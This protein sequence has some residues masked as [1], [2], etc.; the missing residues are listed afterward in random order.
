MANTIKSDVFEIMQYEFKPGT[1]EP[2]NFNE[3]NIVAGLNHKTIKEWAYIKH[4]KDTYT[5]KDYDKFV[6]I[7]P[8]ESPRFEVGD[9]KNVHWH[10]VIKCTPRIDVETVARWFGVPEWQVDVPKGRGKWLDKIEYLTHE[11]PR[12]QEQGKHRYDDSEVQASFDFRKALNERNEHRARYGGDLSQTEQL[13]NDVLTRGVTLK[14]IRDTDP[15]SYQRDYRQLALMRQ[16]YINEFA[17]VP[18]IRMNF[19]IYGPGGTGKGLLSKAIARAMFPDLENDEDIFFEIGGDKV[20]FD[21]Y[22]GQ[23]VIIWNDVRGDKLARSLGGAENLFNVF[24][25]TPTNGRVHIKYGS[26]KLINKIH[27]MNSSVDYSDFIKDV[28]STTEREE[29]TNQL[30]RRIPFVLPMRYKDFDF[31]INKG[32]AEDTT[33]FSQYIAYKKFTVSLQQLQQA[34]KGNKKALRQAEQTLL[35]PVVDKHNEI[36]EKRSVV[37]ENVTPEEILKNVNIDS[38]QEGNIVNF[39]ERT[40]TIIKSEPKYY[41][42]EKCRNCGSIIQR[43]ALPSAKEDQIIAIDSCEKCDGLPF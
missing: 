31:L 12:Q 37:D 8:N 13:R 14:Q 36:V 20:G 9:P 7:N 25:I 18:K 39:T 10:C 21:G 27:I 17:E 19:Y 1:N 26:I 38:F 11:H 6:K 4:D 5:Q 32:I 42:R 29:D 35:A 40:S 30:T 23:P 43:K 16:L 33:E 2:L 41:L 24:D 28:F 15:L 34:G 3:L 22:D